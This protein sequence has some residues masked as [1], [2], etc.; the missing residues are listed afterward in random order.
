MSSSGQPTVP[1]PQHLSLSTGDSCGTSTY[2]MSLSLAT[3]LHER[4]TSTPQGLHFA[5]RPPRFES[6]TSETMC[7]S[8]SSHASTIYTS[9]QTMPM[10]TIVS[11]RNGTGNAYL[12]LAEKIKDIGLNNI[13][14]IAQRSGVAPVMEDPVEIGLNSIM[15]IRRNRGRSSRVISQDSVN[16]EPFASLLSKPPICTVIARQ[17]VS[18]FESRPTH[19]RR[20]RAKT[21]FPTKGD[22]N[23][24]GGIPAVTASVSHSS[25][26]GKVPELVITQCSQ[27]TDVDMVTLDMSC[28]LSPTVM[29]SMSPN[30]TAS[31]RASASILKK[32]AS[33]NLIS[34]RPR[35]ATSA[36]KSTQKCRDQP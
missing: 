2:S 24:T 32:L 31:E 33:L 34:S 1:R 18:K 3:R 36:L 21:E 8:A 5:A 30:V 35:C 23:L 16:G 13:L 14:S 25:F 27:S 10:P 9:A 15:N 20:D 11:A 12:N 28:H 6:L 22:N 29:P 19:V 4:D 7:N 26:Q 17:S